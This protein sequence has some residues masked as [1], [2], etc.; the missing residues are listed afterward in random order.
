MGE[1]SIEVPLTQHKSHMPDSEAELVSD[2]LRYG[3]TIDSGDLMLNW[4]VHVC[5]ANRKLCAEVNGGIEGMSVVTE[6]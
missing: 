2:L 6:S 3:V 4:S 5:S 1:R